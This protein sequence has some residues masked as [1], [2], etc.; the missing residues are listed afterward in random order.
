MLFSSSVR[1]SSGPR[2]TYKGLIVLSVY[3]VVYK[4]RKHN[5][6]KMGEEK[7]DQRKNRGKSRKLPM[8]TEMALYFL[9]AKPKITYLLP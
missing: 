2:K 4:T 5:A 1:G 9:V 8:T 7:S 3:R 6:H